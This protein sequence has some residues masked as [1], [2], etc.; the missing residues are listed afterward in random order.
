M[1][2]I[3]PDLSSSLFKYGPVANVERTLNDKTVG[4]SPLNNFNDIYE[5]E[6]RFVHY[7]KSIEDSKRLLDP[8]PSN[9]INNARKAIDEKLSVSHVSCFSRRA[10][11][12]LMWSHYADH[13][14]G[15]CY[16]FEAKKP[17]TIFSNQTIGWGDVVYSSQLPTVTVYQDHTR[18][19]M[20]EAI[21]SEVILTKPVE[22]AY[23]EEVRFW[24]NGASPAV[25]FDPASLRAIIVGRRT[26]DPEIDSIRSKIDEFNQANGCSVELWFSFRQASSFALGVCNDRGFR[27]SSET[28]I[29]D[30]IPILP[31]GDDSALTE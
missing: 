30:R 21:A 5:S 6:Y 9:A 16:C 20:L 24:T 15:V 14:K 1:N 29:S 10:N 25:A 26:S 7:F 27:G 4:F 12:S 19:N 18:K 2:G 11:I 23:E 22:W 17:E 13:H 31:S 3:L 8:V 28:N